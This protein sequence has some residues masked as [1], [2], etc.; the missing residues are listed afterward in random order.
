MGIKLKKDR[1]KS[2]KLEELVLYIAYKSQNDKY[3]GMTKLNK[4]LYYSDFMSYLYEEEPIVGATYIKKDQGP[5]TP[6]LLSAIERLKEKKKIAISEIS[7]FNFTQKKVVPLK[8]PDIS[9]FKPEE[10]ALVDE[11]IE[12]FKDNTA[13]D[14]SK[15]SHGELGWQAAKMNEII[16]YEAVLVMSPE[17]TA[18]N[19]TSFDIKHVKTLAENFKTRQHRCMK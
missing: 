7:F 5:I 10:I 6:D 1:L 14:I 11:I 18:K 3:F 13:K 8:N 4:L 2:K 12:H 19:I 16:P 15:F 9:C 17:E